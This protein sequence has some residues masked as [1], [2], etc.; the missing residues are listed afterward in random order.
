MAM[1]YSP[2]A[3]GVETGPDV[4][5][6]PNDKKRVALPIDGLVEIILGQSQRGNKRRI[7]VGSRRKIK[8]RENS[9]HK[10]C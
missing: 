8:N 7:K 6:K 1:S 4:L 10:C 2:N 3:E 9:T 5:M